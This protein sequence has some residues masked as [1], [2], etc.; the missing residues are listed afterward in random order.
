[1]TTGETS[2]GE[3]GREIREGTA[4]ESM[5]TRVEGGKGEAIGE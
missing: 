2:E 3:G 5:R 4:K 1:M